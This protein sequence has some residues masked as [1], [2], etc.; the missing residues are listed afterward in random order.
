M[1]K[2]MNKNLKR[3]MAMALCTLSVFGCAMGAVGCNKG[4]NHNNNKNQ[5][6]CTSHFA[7][8]SETSFVRILRMLFSALLR[9][10]ISS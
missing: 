7:I 4:N 2:E 6:N 1:E 3:L 9:G 5:C 8:H 10:S